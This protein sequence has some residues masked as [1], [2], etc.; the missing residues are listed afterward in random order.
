MVRLFSL[1]LKMINCRPCLTT[2]DQYINSVGRQR[3]YTLFVNS[4]GDVVPDSVVY[5][6]TLP[7]SSLFKEK[8]CVLVIMIHS[9]ELQ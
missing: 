2:L 6:F 3:T 1:L 4:I 9:N 8:C 7:F 5:L